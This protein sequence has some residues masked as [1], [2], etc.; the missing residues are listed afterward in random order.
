MLVLCTRLLWELSSTNRPSAFHTGPVLVT[1]NPQCFAAFISFSITHFMASNLLTDSTSPDSTA[2]H[3]NND[4]G[5]DLN[6][7]LVL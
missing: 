1:P 3:S 2:L 4:A 6:S 7:M 5:V